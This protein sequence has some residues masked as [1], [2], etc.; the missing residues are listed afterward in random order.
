[1]SR[2]L[3]VYGT[4]SDADLLAAVIRR[5][6]DPG[7]LV[8]AVAPGFRVVHYPQRI[9]PALVRA[10]G[11]TAA[12]LIILNL[13]AFERDVLDAFEGAEYRRGIVP[14]IAD[15]ELHE[16]DAYLPAIAVAADGPA[17]SL[18]H[19]QA[20]HKRNVLVDEA[21]AAADIRARLIAVGPN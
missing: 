4:L 19:W 6:V 9:Y 11:G 15:S 3:F 8:A 16:A 2:P 7:H 14:V 12:G 13:T 5:R 21:T 10:P 1:M 17:W 18:A 20:H